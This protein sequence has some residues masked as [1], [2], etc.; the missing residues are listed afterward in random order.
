MLEL[1]ALAVAIAALIVARGAYTKVEALTKRVATL[2]TMPRVSHVAA[3]QAEG[4]P[5][6]TADAPAAPAA[7]PTLQPEAPAPQPEPPSGEPQIAAADQPTADA[8]APSPASAPAKAAKPSFEERIGTRWVVWL[9]GLTLAL[10]GLFLVRYSIE[11]GLIGPG[12]RIALGAIFALALLAAGEWMRRKDSADAATG[13]GHAIANIP[14]ILTAAGTTVAY[15]TVFAA[16]ALYDFLAPGSAFVLLGIVAMVTL[17]LALLHG[18]AL[19]AL[20]T[21]AGFVTPILVASDTPDFW[22]LYIYLAVVTAAAFLLARARMWRWLVLTAVGLGLCW[23]MVDIDV[24][25]QFAPHAFHAVAGFVLSALLVVAGLFFGPD[26]EPGRIEPV[27]VLSLAAYLLCAMLLSVVLPGA[28]GALWVFAALVATS[29]LIAWRTEAA[30]AIV[31]IAGAMVALVFLDWTIQSDAVAQVVPG[32]AMAGV[33]P[34]P[35]DAAINLHLILGLGFALA[36]G[37]GSVAMQGRAASAAVSVLWSISGTATPIVILIALYARVAMLDRSIPFAIIA[38]A[39]SAAFAFAAEWLLK[40]DSRPGLPTAIAFYV[41][42]SLAALALALTFAL[43]KGWLTVALALM[44]PAAA[45][46]S[47]R[48][49]VPVLR[50]L[51]AILAIIVTARLAWEPR[52]A[53]DEVGATLIFNWLL[54]GYGVPALSFIVAGIL[55]RRRGDDAPLRIVES[56]AILFTALLIALQIRHAIYSGDIYRADAHLAEIGTQIVA[57]LAMATGLERIHLR[58]RSIVHG[59]AAIVLAALA[60]CGTLFGLFFGVNPAFRAIPVEGVFVNLL[61]LAYALPALLAAI[62]AIIVRAKRPAFYA[63]I[64]AGGA[65]LLALAYVSLQVRRLYHGAILSTGAVGDAEQYT[66]SAVWLAFG[67][68]LLIFGLVKQ[69][70]TARL[71]SAAVIALTVLKA[72]LIDMGDLTGVWRALSFIGLGLVLVAIGWLYQRILFRKSASAE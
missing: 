41:T 32:G 20:G 14:A 22:A 40:R 1:I 31:P 59:V 37:L 25:E 61:L 28:S 38:L 36:F 23:M 54:Y 12:A 30:T 68:A 15:G 29:L 71:A 2:E 55:M 53:G 10:G 63:N 19:A 50:W 42:G 7:I 46:V 17:A 66:Y 64:I 39:L 8:P 65:L 44:A 13:T 9:G 49:P 58:T 45:W 43:E 72:F 27:S 57:A 18:P 5:L 21:V 3:R 47:L 52:I 70:R 67:V 26:K 33:G 11:Q 56:A 35:Y 6:G 48:R 24:G 4:E 69:S 16:Y 60:L 62:L 51:A 34:G